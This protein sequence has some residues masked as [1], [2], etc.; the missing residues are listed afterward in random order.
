MEEEKLLSIASNTMCKDDIQNLLNYLMF[1]NKHLEG[2]K[3]SKI[4]LTYFP[5]DKELRNLFGTFSYHLKNYE[6][7]YQYCYDSLKYSSINHFQDT[8]IYYNQ[9]IVESIKPKPK[10]HFITLTMTTCKRYNLFE[11]TINSFLNCCLDISMIDRWICVDDNS[12]HEDRL[13]MMKKYPFFE[14][15]F[16]TREQKGHRKSMNLIIDMVETPFLFHLED[17]WKFFTKSDYITKCLDVLYKDDKYGQC[18]LNRNYAELPEDYKIPGGISKGDYLIHEFCRTDK[19]KEDFTKRNGYIACSYWAHFSLRPSLFRTKVFKDIGKFSMD[20]VHFEMDYAYK[21][22]NKGFVSTFLDDIYCIHTGRLTT[23]IHDKTKL[24]AYILNNEDQFSKSKKIKTFVINLERRHDRYQKFISQGLDFLN[25]E[26]YNAIDGKRLLPTYQVQRIF[27]YNDY[28][29]KACMVGCALSH[30]DLY[31]RLLN[32]PEHEYYLILE[33]DAY[34]EDK[35]KEYLRNFMENFPDHD[36]IYLGHHSKLIDI[37]HRRI[38]KWSTQES[39]NYS[40]GGTISYIISKKGAKT[41]LDF[42]NKTSMTNCIDTMQQRACD[43]MD[44]YYVLPSLFKSNCYSNNKDAD[45]DIQKDNDSL[46]FTFHQ[47][48]KNEIDFYNDYNIQF[49]NTPIIEDNNITI[50]YGHETP[51]IPFYEIGN[52]MKV[53]LPFMDDHIKNG[54]YIDRLKKND[55]FDISDCLK[56][57]N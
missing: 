18:L 28:N 46:S 40:Y 41:L 36:F 19:E 49:K 29:T 42:I 16:K 14:F 11:M 50:Y 54:R 4:F 3:L 2:Y 53:L 39:M 33:D 12:S 31:I 20:A 23:Q 52:N 15:V 22:V 32:D 5:K 44:V 43:L 55:R 34:I 13:I 27:E 35:D 21:Y 38:E 30:I 45:T 1:S 37:G 48:Y 6:N 57:K 47:R 10:P 24:N 26:R 25:Y 17:D 56:F 51:D 7:S 9:S 8:F